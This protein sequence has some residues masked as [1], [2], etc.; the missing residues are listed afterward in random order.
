MNIQFHPIKN[1]K[2]AGVKP[3]KGI[4]SGIG[5][6]PCFS[7]QYEACTTLPGET[8]GLFG[9]ASVACD[10]GHLAGRMAG[11]FQRN[12]EAELG[13]LGF[14]FEQCALDH[15]GREVEVVGAGGAATGPDGHE[16][17]GRHK[18]R[19]ERVSLLKRRQILRK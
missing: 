8:I 19:T 6:G 3:P 17:P 13:I 14:S 10:G 7:T 5:S 12:Q 11:G 1:G 18:D 16:H 2:A 4:G 9:L 15:L